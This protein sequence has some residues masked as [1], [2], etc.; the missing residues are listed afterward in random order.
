M[1]LRKRKSSVEE[2]AGR[3]L[4]MNVVVVTALIVTVV[5]I[6]T[7]S[8]ADA[9]QQQQQHLQPAIIQSSRVLDDSNVGIVDNN[10][11]ATINTTVTESP[12]SSLSP[13]LSPT[14]ISNS[15][16]IINTTITSNNKDYDCTDCP[17]TDT[18][19][20]PWF[21]EFMG[22]VILF[23]LVQYNIPIPYAACL[24]IFGAIMGA[25]ASLRLANNSLSQSILLW[26]NIDSAVL[27]L[28]FL[29]GLIFKDA[30]EINFNLFAVA[31]WQLWILSFP[32]KLCD[33]QKGLQ[34]FEVLLK[35][36][37]YTAAAAAFV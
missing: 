10:A 31:I 13:S 4:S 17:V 24:F 23:I 15:S 14:S 21:V 2:A 37:D 27:L 5:F 35:Y 16:R 29:P 28:I 36:I 18:M 7:I 30:V 1:S 6:S 32:S 11:A 9:Q 34:Y 19:L 25:F 26:A 8:C 22:C 33:D 12:S 20:F 3:F